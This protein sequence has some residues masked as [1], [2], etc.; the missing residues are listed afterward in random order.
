MNQS[1]VFKPDMVYF[2]ALAEKIARLSGL[3]VELIERVE[4]NCGNGSY[5]G[6]VILKTGE[7][8]TV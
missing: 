1:Q 8:I 7:K 4:I 2:N 3:N 6:V 5:L